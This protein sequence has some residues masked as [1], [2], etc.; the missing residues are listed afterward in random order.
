MKTLV[1][2]ALLLARIPLGGVE[3]QRA[4]LTA[5]QPLFLLGWQSSR[6]E[7]QHVYSA[8]S[9]WATESQW[10]LSPQPLKSRIAH[11]H[12]PWAVLPGGKRHKRWGF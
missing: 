5:T 3:K 6:V 12:S 9:A 4:P 10:L 2:L 11:T 8:R 7:D 1:G